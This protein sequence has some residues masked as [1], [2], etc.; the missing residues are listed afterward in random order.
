MSGWMRR[1][2]LGIGVLAAAAALTWAFLPKPVAVDLA[3]VTRGPMRVT[4]D[5]EGKTRIRE[6]YV[7]SA[8]L[9]GR[10]RRIHLDP[11]DEVRAGATVVA[12]IDP[13]DPD[14]LDARAHAE[15]QAR[16]RGAEAAVERERARREAARSQFD[17]SEEEHTRILKAFEQ[18]AATPREV[19]QKA[20]ARRVAEESYRAAQFDEH[21]VRFE[22]EQARSALIHTEPG[23]AG[24][25]AGMQFAIEAPI[26]GRVLR[27]FQESSAVVGPGAPLLEIGD[28]EDLEVV[29]DVL[30]TD[31]VRVR[32]GD[33]VIVD[34][35]GGDRPLEATVRVVEPSA[36]TKVSA[37]GV[38]EQRV[39]VVADFES[40]LVERPTLGD[41]FRVEGRIVLWEAE[42]VPRLPA[43]ALFRHGEE[44]AVFQVQGARA[45]RRA[46]AVG[47][48]NGV[49]AEVQ[50]G[51]EPG[52]IVI[53]HPSDRVGDGVRVEARSAGG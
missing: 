47:R 27:V 18:G 38:E 41:G 45:V 51:L 53:V 3:E 29:I 40:P 36:F 7:V 42:S 23:A 19:D 24:A 48:Q 32:S 34:R 16:V 8:P 17:L 2:A 46:V 43:S 12:V 14:L 44:W 52:S 26:D 10:V 30:S 15:A 35:W 11:G 28:P 9:A 31:A 13:T 37:L 49:W 22:L 5:E 39:N 25:E 1:V 33:R 21:I 20:S 6:R 4:I 50:G